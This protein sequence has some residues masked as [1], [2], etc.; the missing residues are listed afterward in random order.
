MLLALFPQFRFRRQSSGLGGCWG[1]GPRGS[2]PSRPPM[3]LSRLSANGVLGKN[4]PHQ[5]GPDPEWGMKAQPHS[6]ILCTAPFGG[7]LWLTKPTLS[8][9]PSFP[10]APTSQGPRSVNE[11]GF[12]G[13]P[14]C[15]ARVFPLQAFMRDRWLPIDTEDW[16]SRVRITQVS[17][18]TPAS[19]TRT[20]PQRHWST[21]Q[22]T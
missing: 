20:S 10:R 3:H 4:N 7:A 2:Y 11:Q 5:A 6:L 1:P 12:P 14:G 15:R 18:Q 19:W 13:G 9:D 22:P 16:A 21:C 17:H 8:V